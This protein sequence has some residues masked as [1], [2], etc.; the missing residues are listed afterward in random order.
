MESRGEEVAQVLLS[1]QTKVK[2]HPWA[3]AMVLY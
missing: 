2:T 3:G 1:I